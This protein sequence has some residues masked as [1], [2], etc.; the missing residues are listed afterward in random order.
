MTTATTVPASPAVGDEA[1][2]FTLDSTAG[3]KVS[4]SDFRGK[5]HV[6]LAFFPLAFTSVC[7]AELCDFNTDF[8]RFAGQNV[9]VLPVSVDSVPT[10]KEFKAKLG[11]NVDLL[12]DFKRQASRAYGVLM[13]ETFFS[14]R[15]YFLIDRN[16]RLVWKHVETSPGHKRDNAELLAQIDALR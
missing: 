6:L 4:P 5:Q 3:T 7:T 12:S 8:D 16:G 2:Q 13:E 14:M 10:L 1:P 9:A 11:L 15:S